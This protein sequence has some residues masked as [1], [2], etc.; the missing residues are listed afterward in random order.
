MTSAS[1][2]RT[3]SMKFNHQFYQKNHPSNGRF[4]WFRANSKSELD[5]F[6]LNCEWLVFFSNLRV[7]LL[8]RGLSYHFPLFIQ[9]NKLNWGVKPFRFQNCWL[10]DPN[11]MKIIRQSWK[12]V[13]SSPI[14]WKLK[15]VK[16]ALKNWNLAEYGSIDANNSRLELLLQSFDEIANQRLLD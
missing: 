2:F 5:R 11:C 10:L 8:D 13:E 4:T 16:I 15:S 1:L 12:L 3:F 14:D 6:F 9:S 7:S